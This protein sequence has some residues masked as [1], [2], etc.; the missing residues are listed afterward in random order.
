MTDDMMDWKIKLAADFLTGV[1]PSED[2]DDPHLMET[3]ERLVKLLT[4]MTTPEDFGFTV[5]DNTEMIDQMICVSNIP[6]Y[7]LCRHHIVPYFGVA[8]VAYIPQAK[9]C[10]LSKL[11]RCVHAHAKGLTVQEHLTNDIGDD[12]E[13]KLNPKGVAVV[14]EAEHLCMTMRGVKAAGTMTDTSYMQGVFL[15]PEKQAR[16]EF[17]QLVRSK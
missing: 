10:G 9:I 13:T 16:Q 12:L 17:F 5:F 14:L 3:P 8:H 15:D 1:L 11:A 2:W 7:S 6:F 4:D